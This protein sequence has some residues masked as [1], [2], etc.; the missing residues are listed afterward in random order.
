MSGNRRL[1]RVAT[2]AVALVLAGGALAAC[3]SSDDTKSSSGEKSTQTVRLALDWTPNVNHTGFFVADSKGYY[4]DAGIKLEVL[5]YAQAS[6][7]TLVAAGKAECAITD[8]VTM[9]TS[10]HSGAKEIAVMGIVQRS[11][12]A[13]MARADSGVKTPADLDGKKYGG[14]G[15]P[16]DKLQIANI[17]KVAGGKGDIDY[18][19]LQAGAMDA[20]L[21]KKIDYMSTYLNVEPL[22]AAE[23]GTDVVVMPFTDYGVPDSPSVMLACNT[24]WLADNADLAKDFIAASAKGWDFAQ[25]DPDAAIA[26]LIKANPSSFAGE[27]AEKV[28]TEGLE[29]MAEEGFIVPEGSAAGCLDVDH[30]KSFYDHYQSIGYWAALGIPEPQMDTIAT[31]DYLPSS[32]GG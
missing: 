20:L 5:P 26:L 4:Q 8:P 31:T 3:G 23:R 16:G 28:P 11:L 30:L 7:D 29:M 10:I 2:S 9:A 25:Q 17:I 27:G 21:A 19:T 24:G 22:E 6:S 12:A 13:L 14:F 32:C 18:I 1:T 15:T